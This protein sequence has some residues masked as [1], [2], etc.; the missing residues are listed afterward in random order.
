MTRSL[1]VIFT[2]IVLDAVGIGLIFPILPQL[3]QEITHDDNVAPTIGT[4]TAL[5]AVMQFIFAPLLGALSDRLGRRPVLL[6]SLAGA[7][8]NY[9][10][11]ALAPN[12]LLLF[13]GRAIAGLTSAN[14]SVATAYITDISPEETRARRFGL[15]NAM[16]GLG[17]I[18]GPVLGGVLGD[19]WLRLPFI[20]AAALNGANLLLAF[21][22]LPESRP[23]SRERID[24]AALNPLKPLRS[25]LEVKSLLPVI[26][27]FFL[28]SATGEA[29]GTCWALWG[30]DAFHWKGLAIGLSLGAFGLC[31]TLAQALLPGPAVRLL[32]ERGAV[33]TGVAGVS[34]ALTVMA[35]ANR[36]WMIFAIM[37][38]F[39]LGGIGVPALQSLAT[40]QVDE[41]G[42]GQFQGVLASAVS[43]ASIVAPLGFSSLYFLVRQAWP[44][45]IWLSV[46]AVYA[47]AVP[48]VLGL[49]LRKPAAAAS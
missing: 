48:L 7:A 44:G 40:R 46:I 9:L 39:T 12:L 38:V 33:L 13:I 24:L 47:L 28:F 43:L 42:Q 29:Y 49:G 41:R 1:I 23:G 18:I 45:A 5:Y 17:F 21:F 25:V 4:L 37:P 34:I 6:I 19:H 11:L 22:V 35:F 36:T 8:V 10:F 26:V 20:A 31:Q 3:L 32:G 14:L 15:F 27:L 30:S 2:A 16:F